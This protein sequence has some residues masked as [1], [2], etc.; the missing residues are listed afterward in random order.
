[1]VNIYLAIFIDYPASNSWSSPR[2]EA[3]YHQLSIFAGMA[4]PI[5]P[6]HP[7]IIPRLDPE[8]AAYYNDHLANVPPLHTLPWNPEVRKNPPVAGASEP[9]NVGLVKDIPLSKCKARVFWP[10][11]P[12]KAPEGGWPV[13]LFFHGGLYMDKYLVKAQF[14][15]LTVT[16]Q[17][18]LD[19]W[20]HQHRES[21]LN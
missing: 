21:P 13:F 16:F 9:L 12:S 8:Y 6:L 18:W 10:E 19:A 1:M 4:S 17:R 5:N 14:F 7:D 20:K 2:S 15:L 11:D 3:F